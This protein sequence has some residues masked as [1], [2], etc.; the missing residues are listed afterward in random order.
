M[1]TQQQDDRAMHLATE[2]Q[3][4]QAGRLGEVDEF[5][6]RDV[7]LSCFDEAGGKRRVEWVA[8]DGV[9]LRADVIPAPGTSRR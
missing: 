2:Y 3:S 8:P 5:G 1:T 7:L 4:V 6:D 9:V